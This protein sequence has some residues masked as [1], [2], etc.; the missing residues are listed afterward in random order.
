ML[1]YCRKY[2][3]KCPVKVV[4]LKHTLWTTFL[5]HDAESYLVSLHNNNINNNSYLDL[6]P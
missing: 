4:F 6:D 3:G 5:Y 1:G 2:F